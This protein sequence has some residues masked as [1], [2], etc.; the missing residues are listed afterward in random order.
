VAAGGCQPA[1]AG[2][3]PGVVRVEPQD[4]VERSPGFLGPALGQKEQAQFGLGV[5][6][7]RLLAKGAVVSY[8][9][10]H[11]P[12]LPAMRHYPDP[13]MRSM[14]L[15]A[16]F[17]RSQDAV[18]IVTDHSAYDW[19]FVAAHARLLVDTRNATRAVTGARANLVKAGRRGT[20]PGSAGARR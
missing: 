10:P 11:I 17:H 7:L 20:P 6:V 12:R 16:E 15:T 2:E 18:V 13:D 8:N 1:Q 4:T 3:R 9:D 14:E 19:Q 5:G